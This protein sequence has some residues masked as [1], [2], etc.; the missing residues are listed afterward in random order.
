MIWDFWNFFSSRCKPL[1]KLFGIEF[2]N[3]VQIGEWLQTFSQIGNFIWSKFTKTCWKIWWVYL[4]NLNAL[5]FRK[6]QYRLIGIGIGAEFIVELRDV[7]VVFCTENYSILNFLLCY[8]LWT[9]RSVD[10]I[11][12]SLKSEKVTTHFSTTNVLANTKK[13]LI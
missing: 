10:E 1:I 12:A 7:V 4:V 6:S 11:C 8:W 13:Y 3:V 5:K 2:Q 9:Q